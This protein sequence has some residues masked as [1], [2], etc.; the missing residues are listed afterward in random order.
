MKAAREKQ[1]GSSRSKSEGEEGSAGEGGG[2]A[3]REKVDILPSRRR[4]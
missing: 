4:E 1:V 3:A 2:K